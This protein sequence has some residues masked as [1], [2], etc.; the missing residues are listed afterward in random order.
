[1]GLDGEPFA[2]IILSVAEENPARFDLA[3]EVGPS[4]RKQ[5]EQS[6]GGLSEPLKYRRL[7]CGELRMLQYAKLVE[8]TGCRIGGDALCDKGAILQEG[9]LNLYLKLRT[10]Q[11]GAMKNNCK[12]STVGIGERDA[13]D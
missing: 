11:S 3:Y 2:R 8:R 6:S 4:A 1:V 13:E 9:S 5:G 7:D 12:D 10:A